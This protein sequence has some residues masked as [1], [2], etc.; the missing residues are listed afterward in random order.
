MARHV[1]DYFA[2]AVAIASRLHRPLL[3]R[4]HDDLIQECHVL[5]WEAQVHRYVTVKRSYWIP[6]SYTY[7]MF[8][9]NFFGGV[10]LRVR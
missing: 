2:V 1:H 9:R 5:A 6:G 7:C 8:R 4:F 3:V 10:H